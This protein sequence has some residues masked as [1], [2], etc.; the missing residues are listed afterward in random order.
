[1]ASLIF[2]S[3]CDKDDE[4]PEPELPVETGNKKA[5]NLFSATTGLPLGTVTFFELDDN[6]TKVEILL[7]GLDASANHPAH[8]HSNSGAKGGGIVISL[9]NVVGSSGKSET[10]VSEL[11]DGTAILYD[12]LIN[13]DGHVNV[14]LS[15]TDLGTLVAQGDIGPNEFTLNIEDY[16]LLE[17]G[18]SGIEGDVTF[19]ERV[20]GEIL[21]IISL[22]N[23]PAGGEHPAHVHLNSV[24]MGG[25]IAITLN[26]VNGDTGFSLTDFT[27][28]DD[29]TP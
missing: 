21:A 1:M 17:V 25:G 7:T 19:V 8:I 27:K 13:F 10:I 23:T 15:D 14:H 4:N 29:D 12:D 28:L 16:D 24:A 6:T 9:E 3:S 11:D 2:I 18:G 5:F 22:E 20:S 26:P